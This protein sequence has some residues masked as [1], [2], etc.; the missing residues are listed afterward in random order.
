MWLL[1][2]EGGLSYCG[3]IF[4]L[5]VA[6]AG[7]WPAG[8]RCCKLLIFFPRA[9][10]FQDKSSETMTELTARTIQSKFHGQ[11]KP[12]RKTNIDKIVLPLHVFG[13]SK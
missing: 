7:P 9:Q 13:G 3:D 1:K 8:W 11:S 2:R 12:N 10:G 6:V 5:C 4:F